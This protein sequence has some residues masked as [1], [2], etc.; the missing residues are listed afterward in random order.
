MD[1]R[2]PN[3][4]GNWGGGLLTGTKEE[5]HK[6][7]AVEAAEDVPEGALLDEACLPDPPLLLPEMK[8][9]SHLTWLKQQR[10]LLRV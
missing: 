9:M 6:R 3:S 4:D 5:E 1:S 8:K 7:K 10:L 2:S